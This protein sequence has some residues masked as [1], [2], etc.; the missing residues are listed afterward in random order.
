MYQESSQSFGDAI[1][2]PNRD[3]KT[4]L[5]QNDIVIADNLKSF[6]IIAGNE[7]IS[8]GTAVSS[9]MQGTIDSK[10]LSL[11]GKEV[12]LQIG[13][14]TNEEDYEFIPMG[15]FTIQN[16]KLE[17]NKIS[18]TAYDNLTSKCNSA[19]YSKLSY[20]ADALD[21]LTEIESM[22]G[23]IIKKTG[24]P[25]GIQVSKRAV[26]NESEEDESVITS[27]V[28]PFDGYTYK[29]TIGFIAGL[30]GKFAMCGRTGEIEFRWY[31]DTGYEIDSSIFIM[32]CRKQKKNLY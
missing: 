31:T 19:Y 22:T 16:P 2:G 21:I 27:Y 29:E 30:F 3:F 25:S 18:F 6:E 28:N 10:E 9:Y 11:S 4:R 8:L 13:L 26:A 20:P 15:K 12:M 1:A 32:I 23:V 5:V 7:E 14:L 24:L 17:S